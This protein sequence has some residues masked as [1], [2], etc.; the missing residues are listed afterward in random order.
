[1][2]L[3]KARLLKNQKGMT[4][5]ELLAVVVIIGIIAAIAIPLIAGAV[6]NSRKSSDATSEK[7]IVEAGLR[8]IFDT[9]SF[10]STTISVSDLVAKGYLQSAPIKQT[11]SD[12][13]KPYATF[14]VKQIGDSWAFDDGAGKGFTYGTVAGG[15][16][17]PSST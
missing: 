15:S 3:A 6:N 10:S 12:A 5:I 16:P 8:Y 7:M 9:P 2:I 13:N 17:S 11:G 4:L 14:Y 1:M